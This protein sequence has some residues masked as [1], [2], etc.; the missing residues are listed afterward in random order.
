MRRSG[1]GCGEGRG[2]PRACMPPPSGPPGAMQRGPFAAAMQQARSPLPAPAH[3]PAGPCW[4]AGMQMNLVQ[5][6][7]IILDGGNLTQRNIW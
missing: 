4:R 3:A 5:D 7:V 6:Q 2:G 1:G